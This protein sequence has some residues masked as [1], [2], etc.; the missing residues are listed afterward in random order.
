MRYFR[1]NSTIVVTAEELSSYA[2]KK[3]ISPSALSG[4]FERIDS[5]DTMM[6]GELFD[7]ILSSTVTIGNLTLQINGSPDRVF[8]CDV[9]PVVELITY[10]KK[11]PYKF[12]VSYNA[13]LLAEGVVSA[14]VFAKSELEDTVNLRLTFVSR[15]TGESVS[16]ER[17]YSAE[18]LTKMTEALVSRAE[19][20]IKIFAERESVRIDEIKKLS[21]PYGDI[22]SG[23]HEL[24][25]GVMKTLRRGGKLIASAPT[26]TG[27]TMATLYPAVKAL[28]EKYIDRIFYLTGKTVTGKAAFDAMKLLSEQAPHLR[29]IMIHS[30]ERGCA[31]NHRH[32]SCFVCPRMNDADIGGDIIPYKMRRDMALAEILKEHIMYDS[33]LVSEYAERYKLCPYELSLDISEYCDTIICDYNYV[34]DS[35]VYFRRYF[36]EERGEKYAFLIDECHNLPDRVRASYSETVDERCIDPLLD[37]LKGELLGDHELGIAV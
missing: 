31:E 4:G 7:E 24:M 36:A 23:Q 21:F 33:K 29:C 9:G 28:S 15:D 18:Q 8:P 10:A 6:G 30:K 13:E 32:D 20:F 26:G 14:F 22:R 34:F 12:N 17:C 25:L 19:P 2:V 1:D 27:K 37:L 11:V 5:R 16:F 35:K 3:N